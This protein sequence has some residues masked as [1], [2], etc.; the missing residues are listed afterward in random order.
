[1]QPPAGI[2]GKLHGFGAWQ[3]H[4]EIERTQVFLLGEPGA[5]LDQLTV[6]LF[7]RE[8]SLQRRH[9]KIVEECPCPGLNVGGVPA[10]AR[11]SAV[12]RSGDPTVSYRPGTDYGSKD[13]A[14]GTPE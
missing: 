1:M 3:Q 10:L 9:Q 4:A 13:T 8:C 7:D 12:P 5:L 6:H 11:P 2:C 14:P